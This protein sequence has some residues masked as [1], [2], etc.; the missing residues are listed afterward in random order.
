MKCYNGMRNFEQYKLIIMENMFGKK[1]MI[2]T[3]I[4]F[5]IHDRYLSMIYYA[6]QLVHTLEENLASFLI[7]QI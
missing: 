3:E 5:L 7:Q 2:D 6:R 4:D 1:E